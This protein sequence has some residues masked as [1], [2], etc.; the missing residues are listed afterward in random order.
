MAKNNT[1]TKQETESAFITGTLKSAYTH[2]EKKINKNR[3]EYVETT[4]IITIFADG[5]E[6]MDGS[7]SSKLWDYFSGMYADVPAQWVPDWFKDKT[8]VIVFKSQYNV[9]VK[10]A[11]TNERMS[12]NE[13]VDR[14]LIRGAKIRLKVNLKKQAIYPSALLIEEDGEEYDAFKDF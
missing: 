10:L 7:D 6:S 13:F 3:E 1:T 5:S 9:P 2:S 14:G 11:S 12:F 8:G 4:H